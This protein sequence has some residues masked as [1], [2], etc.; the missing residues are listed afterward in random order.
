M[1]NTRRIE[2]DELAGPSGEDAESKI[3]AVIRTAELAALLAIS[4][5]NVDM[6]V[7]KGVLTKIGPARFDT[8]D[9]IASYC[10][11][12]RRARGNLELDAEKLR[13][14]SEQ[15]DREAIRNAAARGEMVSTADVAREWS[16]ILR[17]LRAAL[18]AVPARIG[19]RLPA[20]TA[21]DVAAIE[22][23]IRSALEDLADDKEDLA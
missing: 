14:V 4:E 17:D 20:L 9:S 18:L 13:L 21:H 12:A 1:K 8:R 19:T 22:T 3:P 5:R 23:E 6:L 2:I 15:A 11:Y 16:S 7:T 10:A